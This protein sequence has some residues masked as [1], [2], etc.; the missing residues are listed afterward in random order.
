MGTHLAGVEAVPWFY[1]PNIAWTLQLLASSIATTV[2]LSSVT[3]LLKQL[4]NDIPHTPFLHCTPFSKL[5]PKW[6]LKTIYLIRSLLF[7]L[8]LSNSLT[9]FSRCRPHPS[10]GSLGAAVFPASEDTSL[11]FFSTTQPHWMASHWHNASCS[12][13]TQDIGT[14]DFSLLFPSFIQRIIIGYIIT[15]CIL[16]SRESGLRQSLRVRIRDQTAVLKPGSDT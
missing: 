10:H 16:Y 2:I 12:L 8:K 13:W 1:F 7:Y 6:S 14:C 9:L 4:P 5:Q 3:W 15:V 11:C